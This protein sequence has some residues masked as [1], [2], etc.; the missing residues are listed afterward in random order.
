M[1]TKD[2]LN[3]MKDQGYPLTLMAGQSG[4]D[5]FALYRHLNKGGALS[6]D[7]K[8]AV[9]RFAMCQPALE[10]KMLRMARRENTKRGKL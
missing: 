1:T 8:A 10:A 2:M 4:V 9:W 7:E 6:S 3:F 5:Y